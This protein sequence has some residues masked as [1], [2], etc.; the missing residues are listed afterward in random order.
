MS[1]IKIKEI[2]DGIRE[3][4]IQVTTL[5]RGAKVRAV[6]FTRTR[7]FVMTE[8][9]RLFVFKVEETAVS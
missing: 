9:G 3:P 4:L 6:T 8:D 7:M 5:P 2:P 1:S